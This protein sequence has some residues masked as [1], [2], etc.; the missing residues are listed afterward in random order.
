M[1]AL[2]EQVAGQRVHVADRGCR[3][4]K[5]HANSSVAVLKASVFHLLYRSEIW[6]KEWRH[7]WTGCQ[8][9]RWIW[10]LLHTAAH[11]MTVCTKEWKKNNN[12]MKLLLSSCATILMTQTK[13]T[14]Y[15]M[16]ERHDELFGLIVDE[17]GCP[18]ELWNRRFGLFFL[19]ISELKQVVVILIC[20]HNCV[21]NGFLLSGVEWIIFKG[22][23]TTTFID[24]L[25]MWEHKKPWC[26]GGLHKI[27]LYYCSLYQKKNKSLFDLLIRWP[28]ES[29]HSRLHLYL[30]LCDWLVLAVE[31]LKARA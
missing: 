28:N 30:F 7:K 1:E 16:S 17:W 11:R 23:G 13:Q 4:S 2:R 18:A 10:L 14:K 19:L 3:A 25:F 26:E 22:S 6:G 15:V 20:L 24:V 27:H 31:K 9:L 29:V 5:L 21:A 12:K 8:Q